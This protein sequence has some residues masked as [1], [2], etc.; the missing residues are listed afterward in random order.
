MADASDI[1]GAFGQV[2]G[3]GGVIPS[4]GTA[5]A[6]P[7][8]IKKG[9]SEQDV[10]SS[11]AL[12]QAMMAYM[13]RSA[14][15]PVLDP[16]AFDSS[17]SAVSGAESRFAMMQMESLHRIT[18]SMLDA[19]SDNIT[20]IAERTRREDSNP[21]HLAKVEEARRDRLGIVESFRSAVDNISKS[22][23]PNAL[24]LVA[25]SLV[26]TA[27]FTGYNA[28]VTD[29]VSTNM[30]S[31][32]PQVDEMS[33]VFSQQAGLMQGDMR[34]ELSM[35]GA[36]MVN[37]AVRYTEIEGMNTS[38]STDPRLAASSYADKILKIVNSDQIGTFL[39][40]LLV[41]KGESS[42]QISPERAAQLSA[43]VKTILL[44]TALA[45]LYKATYGGMTPQ[46]FKDLMTGKMA[47]KTEQESLLVSSLRQNLAAMDPSEKESL[48]DGLANWASSAKLSLEPGKA[49]TAFLS[50]QQTPLDTMPS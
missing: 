2:A 13:I 20:E 9:Y 34:A 46:E 14:D 19:W 39:M 23:N 3:S 32:T 37:L 36:L 35:F 41:S 17:V 5:D 11:A 10:I 12:E 21:I 49:F 15:V 16:S 43:T 25:T 47:P 6:A 22:E 38:K 1:G 7:G 26:I 44:S 4:F 8:A 33:G 18:M 31:F 50:R 29:V 45:A 27:G 40:A 30:V 48:I 24:A 28:G 42:Q